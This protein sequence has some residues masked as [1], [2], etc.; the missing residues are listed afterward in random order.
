MFGIGNAADARRTEL[1]EDGVID[2]LAGDGVRW[3]AAVRR[4]EC[5]LRR[6]EH[7]VAR[8]EVLRE[9]RGAVACWRTA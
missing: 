2:L 4:R 7:D 6:R 8:H 5:A 9:R 3:E 1:L